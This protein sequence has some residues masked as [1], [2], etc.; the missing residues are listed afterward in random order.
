M[1]SHCPSSFMCPVPTIVPFLLLQITTILTFIVIGY[2]RFLI[3]LLSKY[4]LIAIIVKSCHLK[5]L[6]SFQFLVI[7]SLLHH[8][9]LFIMVYL[10]KKPEVLT[11]T[12]CHGLY[13]IDSILTVQIACVSVLCISWKLMDGP[14]TSIRHMFNSLDKTTDHVGFFYQE[15]HNN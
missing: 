10:L 6:L 8:P 7:Q 1:D 9:F 14:K 3:I 2:L 4:V 11:Y 15:A 12:I 5:K 13:F